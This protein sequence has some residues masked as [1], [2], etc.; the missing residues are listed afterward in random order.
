MR[1]HIVAYT[2]IDISDSSALQQQNLN[3]LLQTVALRA[4]PMA[5]DSS[6]MGNQ[7][8]K[9]Y[10]F[11]EDFGNSHNVWLLSFIVEQL[12]VFDNKNG[13]LGGLID[14]IHNVPIITDLMESAPIKPSV[15]DSKNI[16]TRNIYFNKQVL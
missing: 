8:M 2:L 1:E 14:D 7:D 9:D 4:N 3:S 12:N 15:F 16:K 11:G 13:E 5:I 10:D 6:L